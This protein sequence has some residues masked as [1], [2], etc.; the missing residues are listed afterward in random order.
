[1]TPEATLWAA[2]QQMPMVPCR[3]EATHVARFGPD[4][5]CRLEAL[6]GTDEWRAQC[7]GGC[8][9]TG[10]VRSP[11]HDAL[12]LAVTVPGTNYND[13][14]MPDPSVPRIV[15]PQ[16]G[17]MACPFCNGKGHL[18]NDEMIT[19]NPQMVGSD[20][21]CD[22]CGGSGTVPDPSEAGV[23]ARLEA[24]GRLWPIAIILDPDKDVPG[25]WEMTEIMA[26]LMQGD[27][28]GALQ[29]ILE[30]VRALAQ[31]SVQL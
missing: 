20:N 9:G 6:D 4:Q 2:T 30:G 19:F 28:D 8:G 3:G 14:A 31:E 25:G 15:R 21:T 17:G 22:E 10:E 7:G 18:T 27:Y 11:L 24:C 16:P 29:L 13:P 23:V 5:H 26:Y 12:M 1:M